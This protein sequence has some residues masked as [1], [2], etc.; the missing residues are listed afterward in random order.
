M[1]VLS[2]ELWEGRHPQKSQNFIGNTVCPHAMFSLPVLAD[3]QGL[4]SAPHLNYRRN[5]AGKRVEVVDSG[6]KKLQFQP[7]LPLSNAGFCVA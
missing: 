1:T 2:K 7:Q 5:S 6:F 3:D 4:F